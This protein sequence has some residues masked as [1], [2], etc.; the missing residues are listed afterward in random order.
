MSNNTGM[1]IMMTACMAA[2]L[3]I[4]AWLVYLFISLFTF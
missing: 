4:A 2:F 3:V 1:V